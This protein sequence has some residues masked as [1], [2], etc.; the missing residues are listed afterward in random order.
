MATEQSMWHAPLRESQ[1][2]TLLLCSQPA[3][4]TWM[5]CTPA[6]SSVAQVAAGAVTPAATCATEDT[7]GGHGIHV[8]VA[9]CEQRSKVLAWDSHKGACH[10]LCSVATSPCK[11]G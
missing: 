10:M 5:P 4:H 3:T 2:R 1:A 6:V 11:K 8:C 7:A 9:G